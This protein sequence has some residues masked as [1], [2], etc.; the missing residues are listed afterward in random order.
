MQKRGGCMG[1]DINIIKKKDYLYLVELKGPVDNDTH[2]NLEDELNEII[3][4]HTKAIVVDMKDVDY[5]SSIGIKVIIWA[6]KRLKSFNAS[7]AMTNLQP[8]IEKV[9]EAVNI[10][11][12]FNIF[13]DIEEA[14]KYIDHIIKTELDQ[15]GK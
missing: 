8:Q 9:F 6:K 3:N 7:F 5:I 15:Q 1:L 2:Q 4:E 10:L 12:M 11:P 14:D 13:G